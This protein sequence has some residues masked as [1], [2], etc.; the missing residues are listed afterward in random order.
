MS[1]EYESRG[2]IFFHLCD[3]YKKCIE[4]QYIFCMSVPTRRVDGR[5]KN[6]SAH[7]PFIKSSLGATTFHF[8]QSLEFFEIFKDSLEFQESLEF[9][10]KNLWNH[11]TVSGIF[12]E[13][14]ESVEHYQ[15]RWNPNN[16]C[17]T[18]GIFPVLAQDSRFFWN[19]VSKNKFIHPSEENIRVGQ[20]HRTIVHKRL[21]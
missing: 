14:S 6:R 12:S 1:R 21:A 5:G 10:H 16:T 17:G 3:S 15:N 19:L 13:S 8:I 2:F 20:A 11:F 18:F 7:I 9:S 4:I